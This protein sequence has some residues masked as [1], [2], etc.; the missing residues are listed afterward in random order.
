MAANFNQSATG[1]RPAGHSFQATTIPGVA[2]YYT[3]SATGVQCCP[4]SEPYLLHSQRPVL[5]G[6]HHAPRAPFGQHRA[7]WPM[8]PEQRHNE[9]DLTGHDDSSPEPG[10]HGGDSTTSESATVFL[11]IINPQNKKQVINMRTLRDFPCNL[12]TVDDLREELFYVCGESELPPNLKF[13]V[14]YRRVWLISAPIY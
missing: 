10:D 3:L 7:P 6:Q 11:K 5:I 14:G 1:A 4:G 9:V 8:P 12:E 13:D 2:N